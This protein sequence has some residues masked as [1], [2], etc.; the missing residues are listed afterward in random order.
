VVVLAS[1]VGLGLTG[2][3]TAGAIPPPPPN[4]SDSQLHHSRS[5]AHKKAAAVGRLTS[6]VAAAQDKLRS[7][8]DKLEVKKE[9][10][11]KALVDLHD[12]QAAARRA[13]D[14]ADAAKAQVNAAQQRIDDARTK[15]DAFAAGSYEQGNKIGSVSAFLGANGPDEVLA[16]QQLLDAISGSK[17]DALDAMRRARTVKANKD[18]AARAALAEAKKKKAAAADARSRAAS[19]KRAAV[20]AQQSQQSQTAS[21]KAHTAD[22]K[23]QLQAARAKVGNLESQRANYND[24]LQRKKAAEAAAARRAARQAAA[25]Q[26]AARQAAAKKAAAQQAAASQ[27][28]SSGGGS[29]GGGTAPAPPSSSHSVAAVIARARS[30]LGVPY[31]WGGGN[32]S[33]ATRGIHDGGV[34]DS[35]GDYKKIGFDCSG[36]MMYAF[37]A[38]GVHLQHFTGYQYHAGRHVPLSQIQPGDMLFWHTGSYIHHVA[39][40]I[41]NGMMIEAPQS[42][43]VVR[44]SPVRYGGIMPYATRVL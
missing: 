40:Y 14:A 7:L 18:S 35:Y 33:G 42:G 21:L 25:R 3:V 31:A 8:S 43:S 17:L 27:P 26:A 15:M 10:A 24:W 37:A 5:A 2:A 34:A 19:A 36:L 4:P 1:V 38:A 6:K 32:Y 9:L 12:A 22:L 20:D 29:G 23:N 11:N 44:I 30:V 41:G 39:L 16:R 13:D 28:P